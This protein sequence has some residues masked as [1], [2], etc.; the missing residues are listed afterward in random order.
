MTGG[1]GDDALGFPLPGSSVPGRGYAVSVF[2]FDLCFLPDRG[3]VVASAQKEEGPLIQ[4]SSRCSFFKIFLY[5]AI[6]SPDLLFSFCRRK[7][8]SR[9]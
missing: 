6:F 7:S 8:I 2:H 5:V 3:G 1:R 4:Q 9:L